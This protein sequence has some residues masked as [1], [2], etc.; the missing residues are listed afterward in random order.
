[1]KKGMTIEEKKSYA[2]QLGVSISELGSSSGIESEPELDRRILEKERS[3]REQRLWW[4]A[5]ISA[6]ASV[7]SALAAWYAVSL[8]K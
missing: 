3:I 7:L 1:V 2:R 5:L 4:I 8:K 6:L